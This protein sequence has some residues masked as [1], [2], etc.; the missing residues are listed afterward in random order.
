VLKGTASGYCA[1]IIWL[2]CVKSC[3]NIKNKKNEIALAQEL[4]LI[5]LMAASALD[6]TKLMRAGR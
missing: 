6:A 1:F 2:L 3:H 4:V 5:N